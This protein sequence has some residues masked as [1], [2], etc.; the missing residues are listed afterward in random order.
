MSAS[1]GDQP[2]AEKACPPEDACPPLE[3]I[4]PLAEKA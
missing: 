4:S 1:G 2:W 3:E